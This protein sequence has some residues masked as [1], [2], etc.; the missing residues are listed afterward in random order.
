MDTRVK[1]ERKTKKQLINELAQMRQRIV[2]LEQWVEERT[3]ELA[4]VS[5]SL[6][7][8]TAERKRAEGS[9]RENEVRLHQQ[10][11]LA[12]IGQLAGGISHDFGNFLTTIMFYAELLL[13]DPRLPPDLASSAEAILSGSRRAAQLV[14]QIL[15]FSRRTTMKARPIDLIPFINDIVAILRRIL[16]ENIQLVT[17]IGHGEYIV[18]ADPARM[19][20][21][22]VNLALNARD[23]MPE[24]GELHI[25][26]FRVET[27]PGESLPGVE[28]SLPE[29]PPAGMPGGA[30]VCL[31]VS[32]TGT[33]MTEEVRTR[34]FEPFFT[35]KG[36]EGTGLGLA[37][38]YGIVKQHEGHIGVET[39]VGRGTTFRVYLPVYGGKEEKEISEEVSVTPKG[40]GETILFVEDE[41]KVR[42]AG[43][44][45]LES[46]G[47]RVLAAAD[48]QKG[49]EMY[50]AA[51]WV[52]L[53]ITD[54][55]MPEIGGKELLQELRRVNPDIKALAITG[56]MMREDVQELR[57]E[58]FLDIVRK[59]LDVRALGEAVRRALDA[60]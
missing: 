48:G 24:G 49:L 19:E 4:Q 14:R 47:Y 28:L 45:A 16:P 30:W 25:G 29:M 38:V 26:L 23:A 12:T 52:D 22:V 7:A 2:E 3:A 44:E 60:D 9:L 54:M 17:E 55:V 59:P 57:E 34:L 20:Q 39:G 1:D 8:E 43:R 41:E 15:S 13:D 50:Q 10:E 31:A 21:V 5:A 37:Q 58:G 36:P 27:R 51:D 35:T 18:K 42:E 53:V 33:G 11:R 32:D 46:L 6:K 40:K 56:Y